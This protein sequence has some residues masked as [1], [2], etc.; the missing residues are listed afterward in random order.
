MIIRCTHTHIF[1]VCSKI[2]SYFGMVTASAINEAFKTRLTTH[3]IYTSTSS[4]YVRARLN[5]YYYAPKAHLFVFV[6]INIAKFE[7]N[8]L[9]TE[10]SRPPYWRRGIRRLYV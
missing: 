7:A 9:S 6:F 4:I 3:K 1:S 10:I 5:I 8:R 2:V